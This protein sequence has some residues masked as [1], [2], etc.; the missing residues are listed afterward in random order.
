MCKETVVFGIE[1]ILNEVEDY[2][3]RNHKLKTV[4]KTELTKMKGAEVGAS[5][6]KPATIKKKKK[7]MTCY[8]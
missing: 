7:R 3:P 5:Y 4:T 6:T 1:D 8:C 2:F